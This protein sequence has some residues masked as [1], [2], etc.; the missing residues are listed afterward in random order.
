MAKPNRAAHFSRSLVKPST[1]QSFY[2]FLRLAAYMWRWGAGGPSRT[3][4]PYLFMFPPENI[5]VPPKQRLLLGML[6]RWLNAK[7]PPPFDLGWNLRPLFNVVLELKRSAN[8]WNNNPAE[9]SQKSIEPGKNVCVLWKWA[10]FHSQHLS[11]YAVQLRSSYTICQWSWLP[12]DEEEESEAPK[13]VGLWEVSGMDDGEGAVRINPENRWLFPKPHT[14][15]L[16]T[17]HW[18]CNILPYN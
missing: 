6:R 3:W 4:P 14:R 16:F 11:V 15:S 7:L 2:R 1:L 17:T 18:K 12:R 9:I 8:S 13:D 10:V 5:R